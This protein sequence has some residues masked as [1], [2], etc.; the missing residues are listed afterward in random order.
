MHSPF[1]IS[2]ND[3]RPLYQQVKDQLRHRVAIGVLKPGDEI[4]S[5]RQLAADIRVSVIT[6]KRAYLELE[7]EGVIQTR[8]G[9]GSFVSDNVQLGDTMKEQELEGHLRSAVQTALLMNLS[10]DE[11]IERLREVRRKDPQGRS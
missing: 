2:Q 5:I 1:V 11:L 6:I 7:M 8:Q 9:R 3:P 10:E 4:P